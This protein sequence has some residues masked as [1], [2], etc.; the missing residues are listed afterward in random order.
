MGRVG[1]WRKMGSVDCWKRVD[2]ELKNQH[3][4]RQGG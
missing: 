4:L 2:P 3:L 1:G